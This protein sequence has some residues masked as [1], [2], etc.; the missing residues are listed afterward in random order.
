MGERGG[1]GEVRGRI[2]AVGRR[3]RGRDIRLECKVVVQVLGH[4]GVAK[5]KRCLKMGVGSGSWGWG[6]QGG[7]EFA[8]LF[9][10][11]FFFFL[12]STKTQSFS[13]EEGGVEGA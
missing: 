4:G 1:G 10:F 8:F 13:G 7:R 2:K 11:L 3:G 5:G 6:G 12:G 9:L